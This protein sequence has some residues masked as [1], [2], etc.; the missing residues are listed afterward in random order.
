MRVL[1]PWAFIFLSLPLGLFALAFLRERR[2]L[3][4]AVTLAFLVLALSQP[5]IALRQERERVVFVV[6]RSAS[7]GEAALSPFWDLARFAAQRGA[8]IGVVVCGKNAGVVRSPQPGIPKSLDSP[9]EIVPDGTDLGGALDLALALLEQSGQIVL[10][11]DGRD[12]EGKLWAAA[13]RAR[14]VPVHVFPVGKNDPLKLLSF[15]GPEEV[16]LSAKAVFRGKIEAA[17]SLSVRAS[18]LLN[19]EEVERRDLFLEP[20][21]TELTFSPPL[22]GEGLHLVELRLEC[23]EDRVSENNRLS[24]V[25]RVGALPGILVVGEGPS[26]VDSALSSL[27]L[28]FRRLPTLRAQDLAEARLVVLDDFPL[29]LMDPGMVE[30]LRAFAATGGGVLVIQGRRALSSYAGPMEE[31]LPVT[32]AVPERMEAATAALIFVLDRSASMA[33]RAGAVTKLDLL[34]EATAAAAEFVPPQDWLGAIAFDRSPFW[35]ALPGPA[36]KTRP[37]LFSAL[38]G[39]TPSGGTD[40]WPAVLSALSALENVPA[41]IR[42]II[43]VSDGKTVRE[44]RNFRALYDAVEQSGVGVTALALGPDADLE[45][46]AGLAQAGR[47]ELHVV[48]EPQ[49]LRAV[50][51]QETKRTI[52]PRFVSG[53]FPVLPGPAA[54]SPAEWPPIFGYALTFPKPTAHVAAVV[55]SGDPILAFWQAGLGTVAVFNADLRGHWTRTWAEDLRWLPHFSALLERLWPSRQPVQVSWEAV[56]NTLLVRLDVAEEGRW[57]NGLRFSGTFTGPAGTTP[58]EFR[59]VGPGRYEARTPHPGYGAYLLNFA[60]ETGRYSG[61]K[62]LALPYPAEYAEL[63]VDWN[64]VKKIT[65]LTGGKILEDEEIPE[66]SGRVTEWLPLWPA[67]LWA[68]AASF[69]LDLALRKFLPV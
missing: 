27:G 1:W 59:Q 54:L 8:E 21:L 41:R 38:A 46:L 58:L 5:E 64:A 47:G 12:T 63:G 16:P 14:T 39:L 51:V 18:L 57:V 13:A 25:V 17:S 43:I 66:F 62:V 55:P 35:L 28:N 15:Q 45:V 32:Y 10:I 7:V 48:A 23:D 42:H 44:G 29:S 37:L 40:L 33:G 53:E 34:K 22:P 2:I 69:L 24:W 50:L 56:E 65:T 19:G 52:R 4:R 20:G 3:G 26:L 60:E 67:L 9:L 61:T 11:T 68:G 6:D 49:D 31:I 36:E 30:A